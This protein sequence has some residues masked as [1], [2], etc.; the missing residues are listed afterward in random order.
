ME[1]HILSYQTELE[2]FKTEDFS[3]LYEINHT[4][5]SGHFGQVYAGIH[6]A[7]RVPCAIKAVQ[8]KGA[9][10]SDSS[11]RY[12]KVEYKIAKTI[13]HPHIV[14]VYGTLS[15]KENVYII[16]EL[17]KGGHLG[18]RLRGPNHTK[19]GLSEDVVV[20][21]AYQLLLATNFLHQIGIIHRDIKPANIL[22]EDFTDLPRSQLQVK[23]ADFG[24]AKFFKPGSKISGGAGTPYYQA[25]EQ[26]KN[27][28][29]NEK[30]DVW[31]LG[32]VI[33][34]LLTAQMPFGDNPDPQLDKKQRRKRAIEEIV[35]GVVPLDM[36]AGFS[37]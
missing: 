12:L 2:L 30:V 4:L 33:F 32:V 22:C 20:S 1:R 34:E 23:L 16:M 29:F 19:R 18:S 36:L 6:K 26:H 24:I 14:R 11:L 25:P 8:I 7:S 10:S 17:M 35:S 13:S 3:S 15:D 5:G 31:A 9:K 37:E 28:K 21:V 27:E